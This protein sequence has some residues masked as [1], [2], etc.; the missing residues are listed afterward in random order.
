MRLLVLSG[1]RIL[2]AVIA[3]LVPEGVEVEEARTL[4]DASRRLRERPPEAM[5]VNVRPASAPWE[6]LRD[7]CE[8]RN[9]PIP[10]L[11]ESCVF[12][13]PAEA[14]LGRLSRCGHFLEKPYTIE[15]LRNEVE[16]MAAMVDEGK[17][18]D[19]DLLSDELR[20]IQTSPAVVQEGES[21]TQALERIRKTMIQ[22]ALAECEGNRTRAADKLGIS[23]PNLQKMMKRLGVN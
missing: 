14:G 16:R 15:Q 19:F 1:S 17:L 2:P 23:R 7:L 12:H 3:R 6:K 8:R 9:P 21:L 22:E 11:Y 5:I 13:D 20:G 10:V 4:A 18:I